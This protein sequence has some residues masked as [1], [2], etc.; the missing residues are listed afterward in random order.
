MRYYFGKFVK[1]CHP[2]ILLNKNLAYLTAHNVTFGKKITACIVTKTTL[3]L[4][5]L[6]DMIMTAKQRDR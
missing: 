4:A 1:N 5:R 2:I 6:I 3:E